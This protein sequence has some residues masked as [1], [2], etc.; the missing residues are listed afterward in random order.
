MGS[1][2]AICNLQ[3]PHKQ[4]FLRGHDAPVSVVTI[5][6]TGS[7]VVSGQVG[8][9]RHKARAAPVIIWDY[10][11]R[12]PMHRLD[13]HFE[14]VCAAK[15]SPDERYLITTGLEG[16]LSVWDVG[17]GELMSANRRAASPVLIMEWGSV[18]GPSRRPV[19]SFCSAMN[20]QVLLCGI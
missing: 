4:E 16:G 5:S 8:S 3:D 15:F 20:S 1:V 17:T 11:S 13:G 2:I 12:A 6:R 18:S 9:A 10:R 14:S 7:M 19:Y